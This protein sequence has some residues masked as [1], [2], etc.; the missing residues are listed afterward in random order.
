MAP[1]RKRAWSHS[2]GNRVLGCIRGDGETMLDRLAL[3]I[4]QAELALLPAFGI[5]LNSTDWTKAKMLKDGMGRYILGPPTATGPQYLW[6]LPV[7][8][9]PAISANSFLVGAFECAAQI[10][11]RLELEILMSTEHGNNF[12]NNE[13]TTAR[14]SGSRWQ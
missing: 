3:A 1:G 7:V 12:T 6:G 9:T 2:A 5:V 13:I 10:F 4:L 11:D 8:A 14:K